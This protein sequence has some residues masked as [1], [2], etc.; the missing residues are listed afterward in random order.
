MNYL[1]LKIEDLSNGK[2]KAFAAT[3]PELNNS[4]IC[5]DSIKGIF[6][7][8]EDSLQMAKK[9]KIGIFNKDHKKQPNLNK[10]QKNMLLDVLQR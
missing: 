4:V 3:I 9:Y 2:Q 5:A 10:K 1:T 8:V 7:L 6:S